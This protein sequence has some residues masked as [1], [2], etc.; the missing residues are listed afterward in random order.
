M[1][2]ALRKTAWQNATVRDRTIFKY[3]AKR[4]KIFGE[5]ADYET[6][7]GQ[8]WL[9]SADPRITLKDLADLGTLVKGIAGNTTY[10]L[11]KGID[12][13]NPDIK[14]AAVA[15][16]RSDIAPWVQSRVVWPVDLE[17]VEDPYAAVLKAQNTPAVLRASGG[18][19]EGLTPVGTELP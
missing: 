4:L 11:P 1:I 8:E 3:A 15:Q 5:P 12:S 9:L 13:E 17:D 7:S 2:I 19:P 14:K 6:G 18:I 16:L 10:K